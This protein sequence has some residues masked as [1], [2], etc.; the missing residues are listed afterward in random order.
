VGRIFRLPMGFL[1]GLALIVGVPLALLADAAIQAYFGTDTVMPKAAIIVGA[2][3]GV[4]RILVDPFFRQIP[5]IG[6]GIFAVGFVFFLVGLFL[7]YDGYQGDT[8][9]KATWYFAVIIGPAFFLFLPFLVI[10]YTYGLKELPKI[11]N[12]FSIGQGGNAM[13]AG[14][15]TYEKLPDIGSHFLGC[16]LVQDTLLKR[17]VGLPMDDDA[18]FVTIAATGAG[19]SLT[20]ISH[21]LRYYKHPIIVR[22]LQ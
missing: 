15:F 18:H 6:D 20:A 19:K 22:P 21:N 17:D 13:W 11:R 16:T 1:Y 8:L 4:V 2:I 12:M 3:G 7:I 14:P 9:E 5:N 10:R